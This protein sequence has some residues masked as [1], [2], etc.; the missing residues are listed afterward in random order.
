MHPLMKAI[1]HNS[2]YLKF[3]N[4]FLENFT[5]LGKEYHNKIEEILKRPISDPN[6]N[7]GI[8]AWHNILAELTA[9]YILSNKL[10]LKVTGLERVS[11]RYS[12]QNRGK[13]D[14]RVEN[15][16]REIYFDVKDKS[17]ELKQTPPPRLDRKLKEIKSP[18]VISPQL[19]NRNYK[20]DN[21]DQKIETIKNGINQKKKEA[22]QLKRPLYGFR[23]DLEDFEVFLTPKNKDLADNYYG[24]DF[25]NP[26]DS[27]EDS[28]NW[29]FGENSKVKESEPKKP[30]VKIAE[31]KGADYLMC[32]INP[33]IGNGIK[34]FD[35]F[36][37][38]LFSNNVKTAY[39]LKPTSE[40]CKRIRIYE[41]TDIRLGTK[42]SGIIIFLSKGHFRIINNLNSK[43]GFYI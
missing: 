34:T 24:S 30:M 17:S 39:I 22:A 36:I 29:L 41:S 19:R 16:H 10:N 38:G 37:K 3:V 4:N 11:H 7:A 1:I 14:F 5:F 18:F 26:D 23:L 25:F 15:N 42:I 31:E 28:S 32:L 20:C 9:L 33:W 12:V 40:K 6:G 21:L 35:D 43:Y 13:C 8:V 27:I 2:P